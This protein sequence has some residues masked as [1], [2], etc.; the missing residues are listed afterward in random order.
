MRLDVEVNLR[1]QLLWR[2]TSLPAAPRNRMI[3]QHVHAMVLYITRAIASCI[4]ALRSF[5]SRIW[6][7]D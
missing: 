3:V 6:N 1:M 7:W 2:C 5:D 4:P